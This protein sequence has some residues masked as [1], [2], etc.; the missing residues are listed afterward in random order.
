MTRAVLLLVSITG[1]ASAAFAQARPAPQVGWIDHYDGDA[2]DYDIR[3][4]TEHHPPA[5]CWKPVFAGDRVTVYRDTGRIYLNLGNAAP[6]VVCRNAR[7]VSECN[8]Q[9]PF[10]IKAGKPTGGVAAVV[11]WLGDWLTGWAPKLHSAEGRDVRIRGTGEISVVLF[12]AQQ[13]RVAAGRR[14]LYFAWDGGSSPYAITLYRQGVEEAIARV[15]DA[16]GPRLQIPLVDLVPGDYSIEILDSKNQR[17]KRSFGVV[18]A[19]DL[20]AGPPQ[21]AK[22][23]LPYQTRETLIA[24]WLAGQDEGKWMWEAYMRVSDLPA[25]YAPAATL[26]NALENGSA[27]EPPPH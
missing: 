15:K 18:S 21:L 9:S 2:A 14:N 5:C 20:P 26:R 16:E 8:E 17:W 24:G 13:V 7:A 4:G 1:A 22:T 12:E 3:H 19:S 23:N 10:V 11:A 25:D 6:V 27:P